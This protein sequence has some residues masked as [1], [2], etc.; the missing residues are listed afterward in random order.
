M[1]YMTLMH[2]ELRRRY[3]SRVPYNP[4]EVVV[5]YLHRPKVTTI[6]ESKDIDS[7]RIDELVGSVQTYKHIR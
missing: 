2:Y 6:K 5:N 3:K 1:F 7:M 4:S